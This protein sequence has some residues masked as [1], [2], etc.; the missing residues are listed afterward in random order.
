MTAMNDY[1]ICH[2]DIALGCKC[3]SLQNLMSYAEKERK[4][5]NNC[6]NRNALFLT[7]DGNWSPSAPISFLPP[8]PRP[9]PLLPE[10]EPGSWRT[11][12]RRS[13]TSD[14]I[15]PRLLE[16]MPLTKLLVPSNP[17]MHVSWFARAALSHVWRSEPRFPVLLCLPDR[18]MISSTIGHSRQIFIPNVL[19][20]IK[21]SSIMI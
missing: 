19:L 13:W 16:T 2:F 18:M 12:V 7:Q 3:N 9:P 11:L 17:S 8:R 21:T 6:R 1:H 20:T 10:L 15:S 5:S 4:D 14:V